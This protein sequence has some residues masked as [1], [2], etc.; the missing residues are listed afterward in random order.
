MTF[1]LE[2]F[3]SPGV[4]GCSG[5]SFGGFTL[6]LTEGSRDL[7][8]MRLWVFLRRRR[9]RA[10]GESRDRITSKTTTAATA[11]TPHIKLP[12]CMPYSYA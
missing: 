2:D 6:N 10:L 4:V 1:S 5:Y 11:I 12:P 7:E 8:T 9:S 3:W